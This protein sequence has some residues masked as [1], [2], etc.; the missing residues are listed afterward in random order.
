M[1]FFNKYFINKNLRKD[2]I[3][4]FIIISLPFVFFTYLIVPETKVW[5]N[6]WFII[7]SGYFQSAKFFVWFL[8]V[9]VMTLVLLSIWF[10]TCKYFWRYVIF[11]PIAA[12]LHKIFALFKILEFNY[13]YKPHILESIIIIIPFII[14]LLFISKNIGYYRFLKTNN[15]QVNNEINSQMVKLSKFNSENYKSVKRKLI[16]LLNEKDKMSKKEYLGKLIALRD[17]LSV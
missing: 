9:K 6:E 13:D 12:E 4:S 10:V 14:I 8:T 2:L 3:I 15:S 11:I 7:D 1:S 5:Y 17:R 16:K